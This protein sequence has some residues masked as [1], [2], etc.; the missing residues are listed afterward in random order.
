M[1][2]RSPLLLVLAASL[3]PSSALAAE[4][5]PA[6]TAISRPADVE[7]Q[8]R[9]LTSLDLSAVSTLPSP[10]GSVVRLTQRHRGVPVLGR[11]LA[12]RVSGGR[13]S[14]TRGA[15]ARGLTVDVTPAITPAL[16]VTLAARSLDRPGSAGDASLG[17]VPT[18][19]GGR[20]VYRVETAAR[21]GFVVDV[22]ARSG[23][24]LQRR[25]SRL[26]ASGRV[27]AISSEVTPKPVDLTLPSLD[28][29][30]PQHLIG[31]SGGVSVFEYAGANPDG[32]YK[33]TQ[34]I[35]ADADGNFLFDPPKNPLDEH[36][37]FAA[38]N[39][40]FHIGRART[41]YADTLG[42][43]MSSARWP[44]AVVVNVLEDGGSLDNA[45]FSPQALASKSGK[46]NTIIIGQGS[47]TD[48]A[49]D[50]DV[51]LHEFQHYMAH[52]AIGYGQGQLGFDEWG[53]NPF[54][55]AID[56]GTADYFACTINGDSTLGEASLAPL[57]AV[58]DLSEDGQ[59]CVD[60]L[61]GEVH[62]DGKLVGNLTWRVREVLGKDRADAVVW[63]A[64]SM[65][66]ETASLG[67]FARALT[68]AVGDLVAGGGATQAEA[69]AISALV[70]ARGLDDCDRV[71]SI[72]GGKRR[73]IS[74]L[75]LS[76]IGSLFGAS[77]S[78]VIGYGFALTLPFQ[79]SA[80]ATAP[81]YELT[82][83]SPGGPTGAGKTQLLVRKGDR[84]TYSQ[85]SMGQ[86]KPDAFDAAIELTTQKKVLLGTPES[87][88]AITPGETYYFSIMH[89]SCGFHS[90]WTVEGKSLTEPGGAAG[91]GGAAGGAGAAGRGGLA[92]R[93]G[94]G[95][96]AGAAAAEA[97]PVEV[98][99][100]CNCRASGAEG[101]QG[102]ALGA[103]SA[104]AL[105][106]AR[107][108]AT[109]ARARR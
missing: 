10:A 99:G 106:A 43:E 59:R 22:D 100:G 16:A 19:A 25:P 54:T 105:V 79:L 45:A 69:D 13:V 70:T 2:R 74:T 20:L 42:V 104:L 85:G 30:S 49:Y 35:E 101:G 55:G 65:L 73:E 84:V 60:D 67:D 46:K 41:F 39:A 6:G 15:P 92:G 33:V 88:V 37:P 1:R 8:A 93:A 17:V 87:G 90:T 76:Y 63:G 4:W 52:N 75:G 94:G 77:C 58:R 56:E 108:R 98:T 53:Y 44:L 86:L 61:V 68:G 23:D 51:F 102:L 9:A 64:L 107:R 62:E 29:D 31:F 7:V 78:D 40:F 26:H 28:V 48:F 57:G 71:L 32:T 81:Y 66:D 38:V 18:S 50:S 11:A 91:A 47:E 82:I 96:R 109:A 83:G 3:G 36:D 97:V 27:Y 72:D 80:T 89:Q 24:V 34:T 103:L 14:G 21:G 5:L 95:G 12:V